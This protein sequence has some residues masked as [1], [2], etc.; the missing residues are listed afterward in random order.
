MTPELLKAIEQL[1]EVFITTYDP[2]GQ[3]GTVPVWFDYHQG[4]FYVS[5]YPDSMKCRKIRQNPS[6]ELT[7]IT[8]DGLSIT[9]T[10]RFVSE[11]ET[12]ERVAVV[13]DG[14]YT[15]GP[16]DSVEHLAKMWN[17]RQ[18]RVLLEITV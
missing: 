11:Q 6:V 4:N 15:D 13:H 5:T 10:A 3:P 9:G 8:R 12:L 14:K 16:W 2:S 1:Q 18:E 7:W 17:E